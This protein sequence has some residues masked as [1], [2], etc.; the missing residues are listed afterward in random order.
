MAA[1]QGP[2]A[3]GEGAREPR[4]SSTQRVP[5]E[6]W[7]FSRAR[8]AAAAAGTHHR[9]RTRVGARVGPAP[10]PRQGAIPVAADG[11]AGAPARAW[12]RG[13]RSVCRRT[14]VSCSPTCAT[15]GRYDASSTCSGCRWTPSGCCPDLYADPRR[16]A[17]ATPGCDGGRT[18]S[19]DAG[20]CAGMDGRADVPLLDEA[21]RADRRRRRGGPP[22]G[23]GATAPAAGPTWTHARSVLPDGL[24]AH[25]AC[26]PRKRSPTG[27]AET[28]PTLTVAERAESDRSW[29]YGHVIVD[30][31]QELSAMA[32]RSLMR[33][34]PKRS[35]T[36]VGDLAQTGSAG[37]ART[38]RE[39]LDRTSP[40]GGGSRS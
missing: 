32:W 29:T 38:W 20:R 35:M 15:T 11:R 9:E 1:G 12:R 7:T 37:G 2:A 10:Q 24:D 8:R 36:L 34:C 16:I 13:W 4:S 3:D 40:A 5:S 30:E 14:E 28:G 39:V 27:W 33:R 26:S 17:A 19:A 23:Q 21:G 31:A 6:P 18:R 25:A 22:A